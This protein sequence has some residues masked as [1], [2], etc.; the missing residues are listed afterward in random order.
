MTKLRRDGTVLRI[1]EV[2]AGDW[3]P[4]DAVVVEAGRFVTDRTPYPAGDIAPPRSQGRW[5]LIG[6]DFVLWE[7]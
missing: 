4:V 2:A 3:V 6:Q 1:V 7:T 5:S